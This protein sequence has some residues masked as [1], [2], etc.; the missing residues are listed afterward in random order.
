MYEIT[1]RTETTDRVCGRIHAMTLAAC[2]GA[3]RIARHLA[4][5]I[6]EP[7]SYTVTPW[8]PVAR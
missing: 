4:N 2:A 6:G 5:A 1:Y 7:V 3:E 8:H